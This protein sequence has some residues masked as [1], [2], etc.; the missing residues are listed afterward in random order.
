MHRAEAEAYVRYMSQ[1]DE[2]RY[3]GSPPRAWHTG[4]RRSPPSEAPE[5]RRR[6]RPRHGS[7]RTL[8]SNN[9]PSNSRPNSFGGVVPSA[10]PQPSPARERVNPPNLPSNWYPFSHDPRRSLTPHFAR[11]LSAAS[12]GPF[13][14]N[15]GGPGGGRQMPPVMPLHLDP[16]GLGPVHMSNTPHPG[17]TPPL[18]VNPGLHEQAYP[19]THDGGAGMS[20]MEPPAMG[21]GG[22]FSGVPGVATFFQDLPPLAGP[23]YPTASNGSGNHSPQW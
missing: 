23:S 17:F 22:N 4:D 6:T 16:L 15:G 10:P 18:L 19:H 12:H 11:Q 1:R 8:P 9:G 2:N 21:L 13:N 14:Y 5:M 7:V 3:D 20:H